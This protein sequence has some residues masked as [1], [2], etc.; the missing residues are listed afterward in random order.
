MMPKKFW[1]HRTN[2]TPILEHY[3]KQIITLTVLTWETFSLL[4]VLMCYWCITMQHLEVVGLIYNPYKG[5]Y[6]QE[7][8]LCSIFPKDPQNVPGLV[9]LLTYWPTFTLNKQEWPK[10]SSLQQW[11]LTKW[12][13]QMILTNMIHKGWTFDL[14]ELLNSTLICITKESF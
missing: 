12:S 10:W 5:Y 9:L 13:S 4:C 3:V 6:L 11:I 7:N 8:V 1:G 2:I 14:F